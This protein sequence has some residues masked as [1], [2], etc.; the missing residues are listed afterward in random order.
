[1]IETI[2]TALLLGL[3]GSLHCVGMCGTIVTAF[4]LA[5]PKQ[6]FNRTTITVFS[7]NLGRISTYTLLGALAGSISIIADSLGL[8]SV[9][10]V[11]A[12]LLLI[13]TGLY[14]SGV[15]NSLLL[16]E[17]AGNHIWQKLRPLTKHLNPGKSLVHAYAGGLLWGLIPCGLVYSAVGIAVATGSILSSMVFMFAFGMG[18]FFP[19]LVMGVGFTHI[20]QWLRRKSV[21]LIVAATMIV[22]GAW[23]LWGLTNS[24]HSHEHHHSQMS[25]MSDGDQD[26][27]SENKDN[28]EHHHH[29]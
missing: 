25:P 29:H 12:A 6:S 4:S 15:T 19:M 13:L 22:F 11:I 10:R 18:T 7:Y 1:M 5:T 9:L 14:L 21:R 24:N 26:A 28:N 8:L 17:K 27:Q 3:G 16:L 20:S 23:T 2:L